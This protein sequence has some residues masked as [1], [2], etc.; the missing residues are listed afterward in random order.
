[1]AAQPDPGRPIIRR[2]NRSE[3]GN[4]VRDLLG[5]D[6][7]VA[8]LLPPDDSSY[9]FDNIADVLGVSP[10]LL[11]RYLAAADKI[12]SLAVGD[13]EITPGSETF[14]IR[15]DASLDRHIEGL[16]VGTVGGGLLRTTL[17]LDGEY[18][19]QAKLFRTNLGAVRGMESALQLEITVDGERVHLVPFGGG[20]DFLAAI[21]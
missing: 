17:P 21:K 13:P 20:A 4:A 9:G 14:I 5:L 8:A 11:E 19:I 7:D 16:P 12:S 15:H 1:A 6:V 18:A 3:Y 10:V 2:L